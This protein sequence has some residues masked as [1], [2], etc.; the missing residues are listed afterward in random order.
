MVI[1][2][3]ESARGAVCAQ[4]SV[5][6]RVQIERWK[7]AE[8]HGLKVSRETLRKWMQDAGIWLS[9]KRPRAF[10]QPRL[11]RECLGE[12]IQIDGSDHLWF[13][14]R[15]P[16]CT[17][18]VF[19]DDAASTLMRLIGLKLWDHRDA[20]EQMRDLALDHFPA[21]TG[22]PW[23]PRTGSKVSHRGLTSAV[24][25][26]RAYLSAKR[27]KETEVHCPEG[28]PIAFPARIIRPTT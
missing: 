20:F 7:L 11:R 21:A 18:L 25:G 5:K 28:T 14:D 12:L 17:L 19:I 13:E 8:D 22:S 27:R 23:L 3:R 9:R 6:E 16:A 1:Y 4:L 10:H 2:W 24:V 26:S 15:G